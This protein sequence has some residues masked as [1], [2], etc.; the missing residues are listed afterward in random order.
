ML[1]EIIVE[2]GIIQFELYYKRIKNL[3]LRVR[4][5]GSVMVS[6]PMG[7]PQ[8]HIDHFVASRAERI[9][10][11]RDQMIDAHKKEHQERLPELNQLDQIHLLDN[12]AFLN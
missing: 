4:R 7:L 6:A 9:L 11:T 3:N 12:Y 8:K 5:D 2:E 1:R 10:A